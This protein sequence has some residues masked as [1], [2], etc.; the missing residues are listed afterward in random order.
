MC[1]ADLHTKFIKKIK[2]HSCAC[3]CVSVTLR[4]Y[5]DSSTRIR[6]HDRVRLF[7]QIGCVSI[8]S[9]PSRGRAA[10]PRNLEMR[11]QLA[12][13]IV[14]KLHPWLAKNATYEKLA[15]GQE[16]VL[17]FTTVHQCPLKSLCNALSPSMATIQRIGSCFGTTDPGN[18]KHKPR[19]GLSASRPGKAST[20]PYYPTYAKQPLVIL[21][22]RVA[23]DEDDDD[24]RTIPRAG[25]GCGAGVTLRGSR[26]RNCSGNTYDA[27]G[28][29][30]GTGPFTV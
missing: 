13:H 18:P 17:R 15:P 25:I 6:F 27:F 21:G 29:C 2:S 3:R 22:R 19:L 28:G 11:E 14:D 26:G 20:K 12:W 9:F 7:S 23:R 30:K 4:G 16:T 8:K 5:C 10:R 24:A 1:S